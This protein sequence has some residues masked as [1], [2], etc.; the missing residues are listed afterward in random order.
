MIK[1]V[2]AKRIAKLKQ[3]KPTLILLLEP[4]LVG[5]NGLPMKSV[6]LKMKTI[7]I[8]RKNEK[9]VTVSGTKLVSTL[10]SNVIV[11]FVKDGL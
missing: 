7:K 1:P 5:P 6:N 3:K 4:L 2:H 9:T 11:N 8:S 10:T